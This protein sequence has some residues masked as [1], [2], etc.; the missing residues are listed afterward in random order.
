MSLAAKEERLSPSNDPCVFFPLAADPA[1]LETRFGETSQLRKNSRQG[2]ARK[3][4]ALHQGRAWTNSGTALGIEPV[5]RLEGVRSRCTGKERDSE[6]GLDNFDFRYNSSSIGRFMSPDPLGGYISNPQSLNRYAYVLNNPLSLVDP[7]GLQCTSAKMMDPQ[8]NLLGS[9]SDCAPDLGSL[10]TGSAS[11]LVALTPS[12][13]DSEPS[14][15]DLPASDGG[16]S[17]ANSGAGSASSN[18]GLD[19]AQT[20]LAGLG[21]IPGPVGTGANLVNAGISFYRGNYG[22][23][24]LNLAFAIP[25][26]GTIGR[27]GE[28][29]EL[30][31]G[32]IKNTERIESL[33]G[34]AAY[35]IPDELNR[36]EGVIGEVK[37]VRYQAYTNQLRDS[38]AYAQKFGYQ[39]RLY[40]R[41]G[42][43]LSVPLQDAINSGL[44]THIPF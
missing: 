2:F 5:L 27:L 37:N 30:A 7:F 20:S 11:N 18:P 12:P 38:V 36:I 43:K 16:I 29:G 10:P 23:G 1:E 9:A 35:R 25:L 41:Q 6:S 32:I 17:S 13:T 15:E 28:A 14:A 39:F 31:A 24:A 44:I 4:I 42:A 33:T 22:Q 40:I 21:M 19:I 8:G 34:T 26:V 3:N